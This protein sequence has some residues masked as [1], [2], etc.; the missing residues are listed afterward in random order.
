MKLYG[1]KFRKK[2][3][4]GMITV[5]PSNNGNGTD[6]DLKLAANVIREKV[7]CDDSIKLLFITGEGDRSA[8]LREILEINEKDAH[9]WL[10]R[11]RKKRERR[12]KVRKDRQHLTHAA[13]LLPVHLKNGFT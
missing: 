13:A 9:G 3:N 2:G 8:L 4:A 12:Y 6:C 5:Y 10:R 11:K 1:T 7:Q